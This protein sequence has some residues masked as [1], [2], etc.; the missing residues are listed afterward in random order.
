M[1]GIVL[2]GP[3]TESYRRNQRAS[4]AAER[5]RTR[6]DERYERA[7][8]HFEQSPWDAWGKRLGRYTVYLLAAAGFG[9]VGFL[10][11]C[12]AIVS[13]PFLPFVA[14]LIRAGVL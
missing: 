5:I 4:A 13:S 8:G 10:L 12:A 1:R 6:C 14:V 3:G 2:D 7:W 9:V 11:I